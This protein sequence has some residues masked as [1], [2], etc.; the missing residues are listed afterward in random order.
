LPPERRGQPASPRSINPLLIFRNDLPAQVHAVNLAFFAH[1]LLFGGLEMTLGFLAAQTLGLGFGAIGLMFAGM[2]LG[3]AL[4]QGA[5]VRPYGERIG[6][7][8]LAQAGF[9]LHVVGFIILALIP[10]YPSLG[11][12]IAGVAVNAIAT[13]L[14]FPSLATLVSL[15]A[16]PERQGFAMGTFRSASSLG[17]AAGP[18][19]LAVAYFANPAA[20]YWLGAAGMVVPL[21]LVRR[22]VRTH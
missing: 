3:S 5:V 16:P 7:Q 1:T 18:L 21:L 11:L 12:L 6:M 8:R 10:T 9:A 15:A 2:G 13:G 19:V 20:P 17:R 14:V 22:I 4:V